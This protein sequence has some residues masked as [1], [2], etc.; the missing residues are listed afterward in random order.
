MGLPVQLKSVCLSGCREGPL[1]GFKKRGRGPCEVELGCFCSRKVGPEGLPRDTSELVVIV[2][3]CKL[4]GLEGIS[5][6]EVGRHVH[7]S[8]RCQGP[9]GL[10]RL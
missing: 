7:F 3:V 5:V 9:G 4:A 2:S 8:I 10:C 1:P 6:V